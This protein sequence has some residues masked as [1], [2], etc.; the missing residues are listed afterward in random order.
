MSKST[1]SHPLTPT[2]Y[3]PRPQSVQD[4]IFPV[5]S[6]V[7][8][9]NNNLE[10]IP[11]D[12]LGLA[13]RQCIVCL[14]G[15]CDELHRTDPVNSSPTQPPLTRAPNLPGQ[16]AAEHESEPTSDPCPDRSKCEIAVRVT[17]P[18][19]Y[20]IFGSRCLVTW[21][22]KTRIRRPI[23]DALWYKM[24]DP[25][26]LGAMLMESWPHTMKTTEEKGRIE[27]EVRDLRG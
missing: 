25:S 14:N 1:S 22:R 17:R 2:Q 21:L 7:N 3:G 8:F 5:P 20:H 11:I 16:P 26:S 27:Q 10:H 13:H 24:D 9:L 4:L 18:G 12:Q 23:C 6:L 15:M 19:C